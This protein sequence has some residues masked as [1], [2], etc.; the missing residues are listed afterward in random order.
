MKFYAASKKGLCAF[1]ALSVST[2]TVPVMALANGDLA[3]QET[4]L[5]ASVEED[6]TSEEE[7]EDNKEDE[8]SEES[9][10]SEEDEKSEESETSEEDEKSEESETS[11]EIGR[12]SCRERV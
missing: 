11:E 12:A 7:T 2:S 4:A 9:E 8:G 3:G 1:L 6:E 10:T 5:E